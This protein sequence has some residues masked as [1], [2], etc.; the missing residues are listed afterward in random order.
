MVVRRMTYSR[1]PSGM[2]P[3]PTTPR[4]PACTWGGVSY[5]MSQEDSMDLS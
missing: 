4:L 1:G 5:H 3:K 2:R